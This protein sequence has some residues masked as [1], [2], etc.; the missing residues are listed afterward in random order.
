M[1]FFFGADK[2]DCAVIEEDATAFR[3]VVV[4]GKK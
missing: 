4:E 2:F 1:E 3:L